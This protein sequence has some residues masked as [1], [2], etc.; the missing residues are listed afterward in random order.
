MKRRSTLY[1]TRGAMIAALYVAVTWLCSLVGLAS[2][3]IQFRISEAMCILPIFLPE[4][5]PAL[6][7]G[8]ALSNLIANGVFWDILFGSIAS[9]LGAIGARALRALPKKLMWL[10]TVPTVIANTVI[11]PFILIYAYGSTD[12]FWF[13]ATTVFIGEAVCAGIGG[14]ALYYLIKK[15]GLDAKMK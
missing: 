15:R 9:L 11:V 2:G 6:F 8:C 7:I 12:A 4:A 3:V 13:I 10:A 14:S 1:L 5:I